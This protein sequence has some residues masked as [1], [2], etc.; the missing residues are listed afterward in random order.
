MALPLTLI[1]RMPIDRNFLLMFLTTYI[2]TQHVLQTTKVTPNPFF[3][4]SRPPRTYS[5]FHK[6][7]LDSYDILSSLFIGISWCSFLWSNIRWS[8]NLGLIWFAFYLSSHISDLTHL[9]QF[10]TLI[11]VSL[12]DNGIGERQAMHNM[13]FFFGLVKLKFT[14]DQIFAFVSLNQKY[15]LG[16]TT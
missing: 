4:G 12:W 6:L 1:L 5:H 14:H 8:Y 3:L 2:H 7:R 15:L 11:S 9:I 10:A 16:P 13:I